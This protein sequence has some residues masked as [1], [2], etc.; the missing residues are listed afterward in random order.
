MLR[1]EP[2]KPFLPFRFTISAL[3]NIL[4]GHMLLQ[5][6][7]M[8]LRTCELGMPGL[9]NLTHKQLKL[10]RDVGALIPQQTEQLIVHLAGFKDLL[11]CLVVQKVQYAVL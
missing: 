1:L 10:V 5:R 2:L 11:D 6:H 8:Q 3:V 7:K 4:I 9:A